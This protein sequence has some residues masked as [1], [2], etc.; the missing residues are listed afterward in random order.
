MGST[1]DRHCEP[2]NGARPLR[3]GVAPAEARDGSR[4]PPADA[5]THPDHRAADASTDPPPA[6]S[7]AASV[8]P[9][10][11]GE[12]GCC[13]RGPWPAWRSGDI[14]WPRP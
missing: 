13:G 2:A 11:P 4:P 8:A 9:S 7:P 12:D 14:S 10:H 3:A 5:T 1:D 6:T